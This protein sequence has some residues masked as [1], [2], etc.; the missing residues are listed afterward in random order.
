M[1]AILIGVDERFLD[2]EAG[3]ISRP[4]IK[5]IHTIFIEMAITAAIKSVKIVFAISGF[6]P[7][8]LANSKFTVPANRGL[9]IK[10]NKTK[11]THPPIQII[12]RSLTLTER[13]SQKSKPIRSILMKER[14]PKSTSP[15]AKTECAKRPS[16]ASLGKKV[17]FCRYKR[18]KEISPEIT[19][20]DSIILKLS[21]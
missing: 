1:I 12:K 20:T 18:D 9:Q 16:S 21:A 13:I 10:I 17:F 11:T 2:A 3:M 5:S 14:I 15:T 19:N 4:V 6:R 7:S 8:A